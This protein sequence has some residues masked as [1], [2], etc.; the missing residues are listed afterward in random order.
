[1]TIGC[2]PISTSP[3]SGST[4]PCCAARCSGDQFI[5]SPRAWGPAASAPQK[6][7]H[8]IFYVVSETDAPN[9]LCRLRNRCT[10]Y[11]S[12]SGMKWMSGGAQRDSATEPCSGMKWMGGGAKRQCDRALR[13]PRRA[14]GSR[15]AAPCPA[16]A[17]TAPRVISNCHFRKTGTEY[18]GKPGIKWLRCTEK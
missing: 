12:D 16:P 13:A 6:Q 4:A 15:A 17:R 14:R 1:M 8:R 11:V 2:D 5:C 10:E 3:S 9:I 18:D 7:T